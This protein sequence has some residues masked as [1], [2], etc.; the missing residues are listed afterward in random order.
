MLIVFGRMMGGKFAYGILMGKFEDKVRIITE[1]IPILHND[2]ADVVFGESFYKHW[3]DFN[4]LQEELESGIQCIGW[5]KVIERDL[6]LMAPD[7]RNQVKIQS[8]ANNNICLLL[9]PSK[10]LEDG[11]YGFSV[12][13]LVKS[14]G[15]YHE[16]CESMRIPWEVVELGAD[17][18]KTVNL[19]LDM[20]GKYKKKQP[21]VEE[22]DE[23]KVPEFESDGDD[24]DDGGYV[25]PDFDPNA[26]VFY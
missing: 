9:D 26:P 21:F 10:F 5:Y 8:L 17:V 24:H 7:I 25:T 15:I 6:R 12:F 4:K 1:A 20:I 18:D 23:I 11:E 13:S 16:M 22:M 2:H 19:V 3:D 14:A